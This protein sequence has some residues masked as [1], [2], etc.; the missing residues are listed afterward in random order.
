M[1]VTIEGMTMDELLALP[2][3]EWRAL[4]LHG[5]P[6]TFRSG[7]A[8]VLGRFEIV[9]DC[10]ILEL[11]HIDGGGEGVLPAIAVLGQRFA[12]REK[13]ATIEWR[14]HAVNCAKPNLKLRRVLERRG[15]MVRNV[16]GV[17]ECYALESPVESPH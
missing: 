17:G 6:I 10:L 8:Q 11:A 1:A 14:V 4:I 16:A 13:L 7:S 12:Q 5:K 2:A 3:E 9:Q 15:F